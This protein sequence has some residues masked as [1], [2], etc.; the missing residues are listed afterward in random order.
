MHESLKTSFII[1]PFLYN[2]SHYFKKI[3]REE[4]RIAKKLPLPGGVM[5]KPV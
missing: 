5:N 2:E 1:K 4:G 3:M